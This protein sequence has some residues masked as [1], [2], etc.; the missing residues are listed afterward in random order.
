MPLLEV[1]NLK[2]YFDTARGMVRAVDGIN[3]TVEHGKTE[4]LVGESGCG[5]T[6]TAL[7]IMSL[8]PNQ[9]K[10]FDGEIIFEGEDLLQ[11]TPT[12]MG[13]I[14]GKKISMIFQDH[15]SSLNPVLQV[16]KQIEEAIRMHQGLGRMAAREKAIKLLGLVG[17][18][19]PKTRIKDYPHQLSGG[20]R[21]RVM[22]AMALSCNPSLLIADEPTTALDVTIQAQILELLKRLIRELDTSLLLITHD[23]GVVAE[24]CDRV[25]VM[26]AGQIVEQAPTREIFKNPRH[27][28]T[29]GLLNA[30]PRIDRDIN[31]LD[32]V[33][34]VVPNLLCPPDGCRFCSRCPGH[35]KICHLENPGP[36][37]VSPGHLVNC[38]M[39][40]QKGEP[41]V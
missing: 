13:R 28:Y 6:V 5:K 25:S 31:R 4:G 19:S 14:R 9:G 33:N 10:T 39:H 18:S 26:Y 3:L 20:M 22:I 29:R 21:Q 38:W 30:I 24:L 17:I 11:K 15:L 40:G 27:P 16:G 41:D 36:V 23:F 2:T 8:L 1:R 34:G 37:E 35:F 12:E 7:S 32:N